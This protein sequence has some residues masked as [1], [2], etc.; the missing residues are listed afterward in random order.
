M[1]SRLLK[2][3]LAELRQRGAYAVETFAREGIADNPSG[4]VEFYL[5][6]GFT[7]FCDDAEFPLLRLVL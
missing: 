4:S 6:Y 2:E 7:V 1:G 3:I 5:R